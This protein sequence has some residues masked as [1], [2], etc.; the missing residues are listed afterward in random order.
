M[1]DELERFVLVTAIGAT[2]NVID[3]LAN[4]ELCRTFGNSID[5][6][7]IRISDL[8][9]I[10]LTLTE[11]GTGTPYWGDVDADTFNTEQ[12]FRQFYAHASNLRKLSELK[13]ALLE[14]YKDEAEEIE[15]M[16]EHIRI[17]F[18]ERQRF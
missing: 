4:T 1:K 12:I 7:G 13:N 10:D 16:Y 9:V 15:T 5:Y 2:T 14:V 17:T 18:L 3:K 8:C 6:L 11:P